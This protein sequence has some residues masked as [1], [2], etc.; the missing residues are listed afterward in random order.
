M[1]RR[2]RSRVWVIFTCK[3]D[4][5]SPSGLPSGL[6]VSAMVRRAPGPKCSPSSSAA[7][8]WSTGLRRSCPL[9]ESIVNALHLPSS[10]SSLSL[11]G[12]VGVVAALF[13]SIIC[14]VLLVLGH[15]PGLALGVAVVGA[16]TWLLL[17]FAAGLR[18]LPAT[19]VCLLVLGHHPP[20]LGLLISTVASAP[21]P[22]LPCFV[23]CSVTV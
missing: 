16:T 23:L 19:M 11:C 13:L 2:G 17:L 8:S 3:P 7:R 20:G 1:G 12:C 15:C 6:A 22:F 14:L 18:C 9:R 10:G 5:V 4:L 21:P